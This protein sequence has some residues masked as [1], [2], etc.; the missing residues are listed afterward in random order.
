MSGCTCPG[1]KRPRRPDP[2]DHRKGCPA[3]PGPTVWCPCCGAPLTHPRLD[4]TPAYYCACP[5]YGAGAPQEPASAPADPGAG[6]GSTNPA[7]PREGAA[8][9]PQGAPPDPGAV[10]VAIGW[11][12]QLPDGSEGPEGRI[13]ITHPNGWPWDA[14]RV[15]LGTADAAA[16]AA[17]WREP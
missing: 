7:Q 2:A 13:E 17:G 14:W 5:G 1:R 3:F 6:S 15:A 10:V 11:S 12:V 9:G 4:G 16:R 8:T